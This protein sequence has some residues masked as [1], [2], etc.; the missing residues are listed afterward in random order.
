[1]KAKQLWW[2]EGVIYQIYPRSFLDSNQD[3]IGDLNGVYEKLD[4]LQDLGI[5]AIW[6]SPIFPSPDIDFGYDVSNYCDIDPKFGTM[7]DFDRLVEQAH[8]KGIRIILDFVLNHTSD[9]HPWFRESR[10]NVENPYRDW[11]IWHKPPPGKRFPN[12][13]QSVF[14]GSGW[15]LDPQT[16]YFYFHM[17]YPEQP[18]LNWRNPNVRNAMMEIFRF[19]CD[20]GVD[21]FRLDVFNA[22]Y[23][24]ASFP[25]N[26]SKLGIRGFD[27]Q[28]HIYDVDQPE[29]FPALQE[30][31][32][33][34]D[35]YPER[36]AVG[37]TF[38]ESSGRAEKYCGEDLLHGTFNFNLAKSPWNVQ[39]MQNAILAWE[40]SLS[41]EAWPTQVLNNH[42]LPRSATRYG[43]GEHDE[44][45]KVAAGLL[46]TL[47]GTP[48]LYYG[49]EIGMRDIPIRRQD[50]L[51][52]VGRLYWPFYKGRDGCRSP[53]QWEGTVNAGFSKFKPWLPVHINYQ[54]RNVAKQQNDANSLL[55]FYRRMIQVRKENSALQNGSMAVLPSENKYVL[56][57]LRSDNEQQV[58]VICNFS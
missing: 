24:H 16:G 55:S 42:D 51:D 54:E 13:W 10:K 30:I 52:P 57:F 5:D 46:L 56:S 21:G 37:E 38:L 34:L 49:E 35:S 8:N 2:Q 40:K 48:F 36:Y 29:L 6:M 33:L 19:W 31:R 41:P 3:G 53:M 4:Y 15:Q 18:D 20:R 26:P 22:Y 43:G 27:R 25:D 23:K 14:G 9:Q 44:R 58:L 47:R 28:E 7:K 1:M 11:Y 12:N 50:I 45:L 39:K 17:F 32:S